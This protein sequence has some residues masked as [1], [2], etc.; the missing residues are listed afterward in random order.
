MSVKILG[1]TKAIA[2]LGA[3]GKAV[4]SGVKDAITQAT[5]YVEGQVKDSVSG[6]NAEPRS[7]DTGRFL[8]SITS[9]TRGN[10]GTVSSDVEY[11]SV[12][13]YGSSKRTARRHFNNTLARSR[14]KVEDFIRAKVKKAT[15][16]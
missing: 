4:N 10:T 7:V 13:E 5:L 9:N 8:G 14:D 3:R 1:V 6:R 2:Y 12:L 15:K 11:A 16:L